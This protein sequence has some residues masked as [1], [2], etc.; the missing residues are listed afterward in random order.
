VN[1]VNF[2]QNYVTFLK[3]LS[4]IFICPEFCPDPKSK[5]MNTNVKG[6][7]N[8]K[9]TKIIQKFPNITDEDLSYLEGKEKE[10]L[11]ILGYKLGKSKLELLDIIIAL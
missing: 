1:Y 4:C 3:G 6:Y 2:Y 9:K 7:W 8:E 10:M 5:I 11:E